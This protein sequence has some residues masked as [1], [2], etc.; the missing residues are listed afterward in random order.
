M[1]NICFGKNYMKKTTSRRFNP[2][3]GRFCPGGYWNGEFWSGGGGGEF[4][5]GGFCPGRISSGG[6]LS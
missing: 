3:P 4:W 2:L 1:K 5:S 6:I